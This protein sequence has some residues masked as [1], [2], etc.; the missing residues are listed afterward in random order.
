MDYLCAIT[1]LVLENNP[2]IADV[3]RHAQPA[4]QSVRVF[5]VCKESPDWALCALVIEI[6]SSRRHR[7]SFVQRRLMLACRAPRTARNNFLYTL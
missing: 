5:R 4:S 1:G 7:A 3:K 6:Q 2:G